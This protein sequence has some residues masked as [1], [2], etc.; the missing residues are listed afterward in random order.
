MEMLGWGQDGFE[1]ESEKRK[2][3]AIILGLYRNPEST[4][5]GDI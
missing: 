5:M 2:G 4:Q 3:S 1:V